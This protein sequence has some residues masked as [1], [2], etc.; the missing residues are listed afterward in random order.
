MKELFPLFL[1]DIFAWNF[2]LDNFFLF[3]GA[4][5]HASGLNIFPDMICS[6]AQIER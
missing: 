5:E 1:N 6:Y 2:L 4:E 3:L